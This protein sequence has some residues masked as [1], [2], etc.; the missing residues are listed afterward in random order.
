[1]GVASQHNNNEKGASVGE[2]P[3]A[4]PMS[5]YSLGYVL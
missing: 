4:K 3:G 2:I 1:M 5:L